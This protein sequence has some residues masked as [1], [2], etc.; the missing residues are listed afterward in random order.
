MVEASARRGGTRESRKRRD[1]RELYYITHVDNL[2]SIVTKG[3]LS[4]SMVE[5]SGVKYTPIYNKDIVANRKGIRTP[6]GSSLWSFANLYFQARNPMMYKVLV[7]NPLEKIAIVTVRKGI[8][9]KAAYFTDGNA[10]SSETTIYPIDRFGREEQS[11]LRQIDTDWWNSFDGSKRR[12]MA[13]V[14]IP[15]FVPPEYVEAVFVGKQDMAGALR[16]E[17]YRDDRYVMWQAPLF[18]APTRETRLTPYLSV[19]D[20]D[21][22]FSRMQTLT[23]SVNCVGVMGK[24]LASRAKY[25]FPDVYV[26]YQ[27]KCRS[28]RLKLGKP[29]IYKRESSFDEELA[30]EPKSLEHAN[31][32]TWFILFPTKN[33][34]REMSDIRYIERGLEWIKENYR[35]IGITSLAV[36]AL[37]C[38]LGGL[39][40]KDIGPVMCRYLS[41][42][43][44]VQVYLPAEKHVPDKYIMKDYLMQ[45]R[46]S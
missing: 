37:G 45:G 34:W 14:L 31:A 44:P 20:G 22:F 25:Q 26:D 24:G 3:I 1:F 16:D 4:H 35:Q 46:L 32:R 30:D 33:H 7:D 17:F 2:K 38:G 42:D 36:P 15:D 43:I 27:D 18:F 8:L 6:D 12:I 9:S 29:N 13:E 41:L 19:V 5:K 39:D 10:A 23:V 28:G 11:I 21:M 40:W